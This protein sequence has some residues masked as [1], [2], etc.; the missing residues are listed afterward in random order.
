MSSYDSTLAALRESEVRL[1]NEVATTLT[2]LGE[3]AQEDRRRVTEMGQDLRDSFFLVAVI[4]EFNAGKSTFINALINDE[5]LPMGITPTTEA[6][7]MIRYA[8]MPQRI[9][10]VRSEGLREWSHPNIGMAGVAI[11]DTPGIG[12]VFARHE[13]IAR[14]FLHRSDLV[15]FVINAKQAF[16]Q[17][18]KM[19]LEL[20]RDYGK[21]I[22][23]VI[24][25]IDT[26]NANEQAEV[27][28]FV[29]GRVRELLD[30]QPL[31]FTASAKEALIA[32]K[33]QPV[34]A[35]VSATDSG[36]VPLTTAPT[37]DGNFTAIR[38]HLR[39]VFSEAPPA[40][41]KLI[42]QLDTLERIVKIHADTIQGKADAV[43]SD[44]TRAKDIQRELEQ[45]ALGMTAQLQRAR[46]DLDHV[47]EG[48]RTRGLAFIDAQLSL[49]RVTRGSSKEA[50][51]SEFQEKVIANAMRDANAATNDYVNAVIDHGRMYWRSV[52]E[53]LNQI[54]EKIEQSAT[55]LDAGVYAE[56]RES[57]QEAI[58]MAEGELRTYSSGKIV[59][60]LD[61]L[62]Q[63]NLNA[64]ALSSAAAV[65][66]GIAVILAVAAPGG[67]LASSFPLVLPAVIV[68]APIAV[69]GG[70][71]AWY[72][73]RKLTNDSKKDFNAKVDK[74]IKT[75]HDTLDTLVQK[76]RNRLTQYG[77]QILTPIFSTLET[78]AG[79]LSNQSTT[80]KNHLAQIDLLR[81]GIGNIP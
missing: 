73:Y 13:K 77:N 48:V 52:I 67:I 12:S 16:G 51:Q 54:K 53:R 81:K 60:Q 35:A 47:F 14:D 18:E 76:E 9:P 61:L 1:M 69:L 39:G 10:Q 33:A 55:G 38:A 50:L 62:S 58:V 19:Y 49:K 30:I 5:L 17:S 56:Q 25:Q 66:G 15:I 65:A 42:T 24:N 68:G 79:R 27:K 80:F 22:I 46:A 34:G 21:K 45:Q 8:E 29:E 32:R 78:Q 43:T 3:A 7:E 64:L 37:N 36:A 11:V 70:A 75:Y 44:Q 40:R 4:G 59:Q 20:A 23:I 72:Y 2:G 26:L 31:I 63:N 6:I 41:Q 71:A 57:L 28:R 74:L